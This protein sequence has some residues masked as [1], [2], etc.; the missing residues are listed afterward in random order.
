MNST[1]FHI[2]NAS[3][4]SGKTYTL[5]KEYLKIL[6][7]DDLVHHFKQMLAVTFTN[8]AVY[9]MKERILTSLSAFSE[10]DAVVRPPDMLAALAGELEVSVETLQRRARNVLK[11][12]LHNYAFFDIVTI[13]KFNHRIIRAFAYDLKLPSNFEVALDTVPLLEEAVDNLIYKAGEDTLLTKALVD[14]AVEKADD[15][16]SWDIAIDLREIAQL[17][18][19]ENHYEHVEQLRERTLNDFLALGRRLKSTIKKQESAIKAGAESVL[20]LLEANGLEASDFSRGTLPNHFKKMAVLDFNGLYANKLAENLAEAAVYPKTLP[21]D[22]AFAIDALLPEL[23]KAYHRLKKAVFNVKFLRNFYKNIVPLSLLNA[24]RNELEALKEERNMV[25]ISE[26][27]SII[28][29]AIA[30]QPAPFIYERL[31]EKYRHYF[32]DEFQDTSQ[33]QWDNLKPLIGNALE[34]ET[35]AGQRG[36]LY[37][38]GDAKQAIYRWRGGK[39]EQFIDLYRCQNPFQVEK[40]VTVLPKNRRSF[41]EIVAFNNGFFSHISEFLTHPG[42]RDLYKNRSF[43]ETGDKMGGMVSLS[44]IAKDDGDAAYC[45]EVLR[46]IRQAVA[47]GFAYNDICVLTRKRSEGVTVADYLLEQGVKIVSSETLLLK[48]NPKVDFLINLL[49]CLLY[50]HDK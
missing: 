3:A 26:F 35:L 8:K 34:S 48:N 4:G 2:Y 23:S 12:I 21:E 10:D 20:E 25:L 1:Q 43:Q 19:E 40:A 45:G 41:S 42:Y 27:N 39:P 6:F 47:Q 5:V 50:P 38:V 13:D 33:M 9:E 44:F 32:I 30:N 22:K 17:L 31:G 24:V 7:S 11:H 28:S 46:Y 37:I 14:F 15:D 49:L 36:T 18:L 29:K 16:K